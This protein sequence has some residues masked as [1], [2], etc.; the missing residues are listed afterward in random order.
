MPAI[1]QPESYDAWL[2]RT[3]DPAVLNKLLMPFPASKMTSHRVSRAVNNPEKDGSD[4]IIGVA[5]G[6]LGAERIFL[7]LD[8]NLKRD[9]LRPNRI[10][11]SN[12]HNQTISTQSVR[13]R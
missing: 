3:T 10:S 1:L 11:G 2:D 12:E 9:Q 7:P 6:Y 8:L 4:L 13:T 5:M